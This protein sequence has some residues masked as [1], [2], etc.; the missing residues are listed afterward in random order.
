MTHTCEPFFPTSLKYHACS[1]LQL[2]LLQVRQDYASVADFIK[3]SVLDSASKLN[4]GADQL[5]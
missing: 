3:I 2:C 5:Q 4:S 1:N